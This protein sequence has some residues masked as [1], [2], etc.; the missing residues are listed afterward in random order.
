[1]TRVNSLLELA[2]VRNRWKKE[3]WICICETF[4][5]E[6]FSKN[7]HLKLYWLLQFGSR[8]KTLLQNFTTV[9]T[10]DLNKDLPS[11]ALVKVLAQDSVT[12]SSKLGVR[13]SSS[14]RL[15]RRLPRWDIGESSGKH[16]PTHVLATVPTLYLKKNFPSKT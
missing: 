9:P 13:N 15:K 7:L 1:M 3:F 14:S 12:L 8:S 10:C 4:K 2:H 5:P 11:K 16:F 6:I